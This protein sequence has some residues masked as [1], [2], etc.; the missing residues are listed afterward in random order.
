MADAS[1]DSDLS[2][3]A[4][5]GEIQPGDAAADESSS[6]A[7][8][9]ARWYTGV[10]IAS[11]IGV[12]AVWELVSALKLYPPLFLPSPM[13]VA[14]TFYSLLV[15][16]YG[17]HTLLAQ[18]GYSLARVLVAFLLAVVTGVPLG[19][20]MGRSKMF[21]SVV[22]PFMQLYRPVPPLAFI[23]LLI[24]WFGIG[25]LPKVLLIYLGTVP[26]II[27]DTMAGVHSV[28][29]AAVL[30]AE[31]LGATRVQVLRYVVLPSVLP[32]I[33]VGMRVGIGIAWTCLVAAEM[34]AA[35][36]GLGWMILHSSRYLR[37]DA[38]FVGIL[39]I[40]VCG[41]LMDAL[42]RWMEHRFIPWRG[43]Y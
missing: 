28:K 23:P 33:F 41:V 2:R 3:D 21:E 43:K 15:E 27:M 7:P 42:L 40:G 26:I 4:A 16:P 6:A 10:S 19:L 13:L 37:T 17:G 20:L 34:I 29:Q 36:T 14:K 25:E 31:S 22:N 12:L 5:L 39:V 35:V 11:I 24:V 9:S 8:R 1:F 18:T 38:I 30:T 32:S